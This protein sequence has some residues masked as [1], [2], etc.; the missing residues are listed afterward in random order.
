MQTLAR[1]MV[2]DGGEPLLRQRVVAT[3]AGTGMLLAMLLLP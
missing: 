1:S 2:V 3:A